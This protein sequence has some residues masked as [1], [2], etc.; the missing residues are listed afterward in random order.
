MNRLLQNKFLVA[1]LVFGMFAMG[2][3]IVAKQNNLSSNGK[4]GLG[5][6]KKSDL[7]QR[8]T[9]AG[10]V[11]PNRKTII[12][13]PYNGY[14]R[15]IFVKIGDRVKQGDPIVSIVQ[16][17]QSSDPVYP[18][19]APFPGTVV[20]VEK[21]EGEYIK[22]GDAKEFVVRID[23]LEKLFVLTNAPEIDRVKIKAGQ[24]AVIKA[25]AILTRSYKGIIR[26][27]SL[28][29][30]EKEQWGQSQVEFPIRVE[31]LDQDQELSPGM[32]VVI[33]IITN[34]KEN[35]L[36]LRHEF[37]HRENEKYFVI[38]KNGKKR[39]IEV[40]IQNEEAFEIRDGLKEGEQ[41]QQINFST[42][43][44]NE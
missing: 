28:A 17:L 1:L 13:A 3:V 20:Q 5:S 37:I 22:E 23:D 18:L 39:S 15:K 8:V 41:V 19:R 30:K 16:S 42:L 43:I 11:V 32:S 29:A 7:I 35:V 36:T 10:V 34:K 12:T 33:D 2:F 14:I 25:S 27:L 24:E 31:V 40:G 4:E 26:E 44:Q 38:L 21:N 6:V 9:I